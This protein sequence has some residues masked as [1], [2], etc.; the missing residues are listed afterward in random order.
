MVAR[1]GY[2]ASPRE[3]GPPVWG[4]DE[5]INRRDLEEWIW[6]ALLIIT[7]AIMIGL[8]VWPWIS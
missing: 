1:P 2:P 7:V 6:I 8:T 5:P 4:Q 3:A